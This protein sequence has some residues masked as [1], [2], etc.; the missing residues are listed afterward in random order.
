MNVL[1]GVAVSIVVLA[2]SWASPLTDPQVPDFLVLEAAVE[3]EL[4]AGVE[5]VH[6][7]D[8]CAD[9]LAD[10][11]QDVLELCESVFHDFLAV[12]FLHE[13]HGEVFEANDGVLFT[14][15]LGEMPAGGPLMCMSLCT[16][17]LTL[18]IK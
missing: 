9:L 14:E 6:L 18:L 5:L 17:V 13:F 7:D 1:C 4:R 12:A 3:A 15:F 10:I 16:F 11:L 2:T 8:S